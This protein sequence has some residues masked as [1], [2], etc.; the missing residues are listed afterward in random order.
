MSKERWPGEK[1]EKELKSASERGFL[2][3][4]VG[5]STVGMKCQIEK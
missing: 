1:K 5:R 2:K 3:D 4:G